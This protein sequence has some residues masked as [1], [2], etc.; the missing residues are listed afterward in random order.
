[1]NFDFIYII[2][3]LCFGAIIEIFVGKLTDFTVDKIYEKK[4]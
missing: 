3:L 1:M 2:A 4:I